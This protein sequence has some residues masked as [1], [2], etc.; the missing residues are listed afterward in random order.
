MLFS[1]V[2]KTVALLALS[3]APALALPATETNN[4]AVPGAGY[5]DSQFDARALRWPARLR[6]PERQDTR[7]HPY[8]PVRPPNAPPRVP[9][10]PLK[11]RIKDKIKAIPDKLR[12]KPKTQSSQSSQESPAQAAE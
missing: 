11:Q 2:L 12:R 8:P 3:A 5:G 10:P 1:A 7:V 6:V 9:R 4:L